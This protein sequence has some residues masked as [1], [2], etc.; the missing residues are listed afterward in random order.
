MR[1]NAFDCTRLPLGRYLVFQRIAQDGATARTWYLSGRSLGRLSF[2]LLVQTRDDCYGQPRNRPPGLWKRVQ[3]AVIRSNGRTAMY[4]CPDL[5]PSRAGI[6]LALP[7]YRAELGWGA[8]GTRRRPSTC[9]GQAP[10]ARQL[11]GAVRWTK[12]KARP[13]PNSDRFYA[14]TI[15]SP[16][17]NTAA[18]SW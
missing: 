9:S 13:L 17:T 7:R 1:L 3:R 2:R 18:A 11:D 6:A 12:R 15:A 14:M 10:R 5:P 16:K 4:C 8:A